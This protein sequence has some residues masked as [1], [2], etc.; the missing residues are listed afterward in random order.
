MLAS[1]IIVMVVITGLLLRAIYLQDRGEYERAD[2]W[3]FPALGLFA[4]LVVVVL[5]HAAVT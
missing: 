1:L 2:R 5:I 4:A 3:G